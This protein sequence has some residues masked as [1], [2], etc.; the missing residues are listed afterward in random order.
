MLQ[1]MPFYVSTRLVA[2]SQCGGLEQPL[3]LVHVQV[4]HIPWLD[5]VHAPKGACKP[6]HKQKVKF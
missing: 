2:F 5:V 1:K 4:Q 6:P 3:H